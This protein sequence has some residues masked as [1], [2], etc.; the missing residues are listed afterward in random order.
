MICIKAEIPVEIC[1][2][3]DELKAITTVKIL[4]VFG[5]LNLDWIEIS[6]LMKLLEWKK[7]IEKIITI[8]FINKKPHYTKWG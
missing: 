5:F 6:L 7:K 8:V 3:D 1:Q 2:I 4:C